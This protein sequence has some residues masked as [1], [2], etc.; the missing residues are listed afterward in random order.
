MTTVGAVVPPRDRWHDCA[1]FWQYEVSTHA[2]GHAY[3]PMMRYSD[4]KPPAMDTAFLPGPRLPRTRGCGGFTLMELL[5]VIA[6]IAILAAL[7]FPAAQRMIASGQTAKATGNLRQIGSLL[8]S[9]TGDNNNRLPS[10]EPP[11]WSA[12]TN[13]KFWQNLLRMHAGMPVRGNPATDPWLPE[14]FYDPVVKKGRQH[15]FGCFGGNSAVMKRPNGLPLASLAAPGQ[16]VVVA[17][18]MDVSVKQRFDSSWYFDGQRVTRG[19]AQADPRHR[20]SAL[21]L[22]ADGHVEALD[23]TKMDAEQLRKYFRPDGK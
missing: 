20:G 19:S 21:C 12:A 13:S 2:T 18:A 15:L 8:A 5:V 22:F 3:C 4:L 7:A 11:A 23:I 16:T 6:I 1:R 9:Y 17:S 14:C 10:A